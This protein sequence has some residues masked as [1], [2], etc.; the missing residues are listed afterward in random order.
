MPYRKTPLVINQFYHVFNRSIARQPIFLNK[1]DYQRMIQVIDFYRYPK[2]RLRFSFFD[3]LPSDEK[4]NF[5]RELRKEMP[6]VEIISYCLMPNHFHFLL[7]P[8]ADFGI[9]DFIRNIQ[10]S[11]SK[12]FNVKNDRSGSLFQGMFKAVLIET[13]EQFVHVSRYIHLNP[14]SSYLIE[15]DQLENYPW[16]SFKEYVAK[17][18]NSTFLDKKLI[19]EWFKSA[20]NYKQFVL[21]QA[22]YQR[23]LEEIKH[24][25][26]E[27]IE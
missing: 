9:S 21:D 26:I 11:Y 12:Y 2:P 20:E 25:I 17:S 5:L 18:S 22:D 1:R 8:I 19:M 24:L 16:S 6:I 14:V 4:E 23:G 27:K 3:R 13:D 7:R 10:H 15:A